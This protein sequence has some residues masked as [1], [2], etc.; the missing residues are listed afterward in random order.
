MSKRTGPTNPVLRRL[1][2]SLR[3]E[4]ASSSAA[5]WKRLADDLE[6]PSRIRRAVNVSSIARFAKPNEI[7]VVPGKVLGGGVISEGV[8]VAALSFS[9]SSKQKIEASK[10]KT[11]SIVELM[12]QNPK[13]KD[14]RI[15]G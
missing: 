9:G 3:K 10:G 11:L 12:T 7:V 15:I 1:I 5:L 14:V 2:S 4:S 8:V 13:G 6:K